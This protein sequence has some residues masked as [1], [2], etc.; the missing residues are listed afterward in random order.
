[1]LQPIV[2]YLR[3]FAWVWWRLHSSPPQDSHVRG[4]ALY[5][6]GLAVRARPPGPGARNIQHSG[7]DLHGWHRAGAPLS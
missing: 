6:S 5:G 3:H 2:L 7:S 1:M 4:K